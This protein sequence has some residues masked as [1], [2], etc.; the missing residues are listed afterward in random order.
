MWIKSKINGKDLPVMIDTGATSRCTAQ[1][2]V[3]TSS[4]IPKLLQG[5]YVGTG[6]LQYVTMSV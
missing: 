4:N 3:E 6:L 5:V 1:H 2:C